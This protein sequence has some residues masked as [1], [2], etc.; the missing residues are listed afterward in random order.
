MPTNR[1]EQREGG[2]VFEG[3]DHVLRGLQQQLDFWQAESGHAEARRHMVPA[4]ERATVSLREALQR[5]KQE[6]G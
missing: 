3:A 4:L 2:N 5:A 1:A 6:H